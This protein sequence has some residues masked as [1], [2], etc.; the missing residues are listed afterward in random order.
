MKLKVCRNAHNISHYKNY[1]FYCLGLDIINK[2]KS[3]VTFNI[4]VQYRT[5]MERLNET[6]LGKLKFDWY[7][8]D[9]MMWIPFRESFGDT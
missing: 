8:I 2:N 6:Y 9:C 5:I 3:S 1:V 7:I 4:I